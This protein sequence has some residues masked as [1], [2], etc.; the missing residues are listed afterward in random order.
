MIDNGVPWLVDLV[1]YCKGAFV[2][3]AGVFGAYVLA[4]GAD[5]P[6]IVSAVGTAF[7]TLSVR[8]FYG[9]PIAVLAGLT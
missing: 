7:G 2:A 1:K 3:I 9:V 4:C 6:E 5:V 8:E